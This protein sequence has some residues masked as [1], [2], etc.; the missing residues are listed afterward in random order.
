M[1]HTHHIPTD[2]YL[3]AIDS[4]FPNVTQQYPIDISIDGKAWVALYPTNH[5]SNFLKDSFV[6]FTIDSEPGCFIDYSSFN[7]EFNLQL[8]KENGEALP[9]DSTVIL[10][11]GLIHS[12]FS[13]GKKFLNSQL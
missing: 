13:S 8:L 2:R 9:H 1:Y 11:N 4:H 3:P 10:V 6:E 12:L 7:I 5:D